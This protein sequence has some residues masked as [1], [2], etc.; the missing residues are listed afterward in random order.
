MIILLSLPKQR[1]LWR[2]KLLFYTEHLPSENPLILN[3]EF[4]ILNYFSI[5]LV[6]PPS[7]STVPSSSAK[8]SKGSTDR[9]AVISAN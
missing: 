4:L 7:V 2:D 5:A 1:L 9:Y 8:P 3:S 6:C